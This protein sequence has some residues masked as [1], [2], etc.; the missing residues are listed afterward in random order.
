MRPCV[1][2]FRVK[3]QRMKTV[4]R[5]WDEPTIALDRCYDASVVTAGLPWLPELIVHSA[6]MH[7]IAC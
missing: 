6:H 3:G 2:Q 1:G 7:S 4:R 5:V